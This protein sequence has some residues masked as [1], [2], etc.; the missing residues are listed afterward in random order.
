MSR[1]LA[2]LQRRENC[3]ANSVIEQSIV[4]FLTGG[5][6]QFF[7]LFSC[8]PQNVLAEPGKGFMIAMKAFDKTRPP[9]SLHNYCIIVLRCGKA[10]RSMY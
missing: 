4:H 10:V 9:V 2:Y 5:M 8:S 7:F 1:C 3:S 6:N